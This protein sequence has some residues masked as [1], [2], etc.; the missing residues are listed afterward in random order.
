MSL[1]QSIYL[2][3][4]SLWW[5]RGRAI[6][7]VLCL[8][9]TIWLPLTI[10][11]VLN[12]FRE[13]IVLRARSTPLIIGAR[14]SQI[15]LALHSLYFD[16]VAP[17]QTTMAEARY[18]DET[19][20]ALA[21][22]L[23]AVY[24]TQSVNNQDGAPI[25]GTTIDYFEFRGL[26]LHSGT[27]MAILGDCVVGAT[28]AER[29]G[30]RPGDHVLSAP[31]NAFN[32]AGDYPLRMNITGVLRRSHSPDDNAVFVD[33]KTAWIIDGIG[34]GHQG[35]T[36]EDK[37]LLLDADETSVTASAAVLPY[38]EITPENLSSFHFHG[39]PDTFPITAVIAVPP[40]RRQQTLLLG[41]YAT[42]RADTALCVKPRQVVE[43]LLSIVFRVERLIWISSLLSAVVTALLL[44]LVIMLS[45]RLRARE[46]QTMNKLGCSRYT[47][48][49]LLGTEIGIL[50]LLGLGL[51]TTAAWATSL[52]A[53]DSLRSLL[54]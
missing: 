30:L 2:A 42:E 13:E 37:E 14:G 31:K 32:L 22:P 17:Q 15:D 51:A 36:H 18:V 24:R 41:R 10:R 6:T 11:L 7:V 44:G 16:T 4:R 53:A 54:F 35:L 34:H 49:K 9:L 3:F 39:D 52:V 48:L 50:T 26:T 28:V 5:F 29:L 19:G 45:V 8:A 38:T 20:F 23:H 12:Q 40:E 47:V 27:G 1:T 46:I 21:I 33:V 25:V 43:D